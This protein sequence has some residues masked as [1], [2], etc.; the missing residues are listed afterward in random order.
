MKE[1]P[2]KAVELL[3]GRLTWAM[4]QHGRPALTVFSSMDENALATTNYLWSGPD[5]EET[6]RAALIGLL[7]GLLVRMKELDMA[8]SKNAELYREYHIAGIKAGY[9]IRG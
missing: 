5:I 2:D 6:D 7:S 1:E 3:K 9:Q 8:D 4:D